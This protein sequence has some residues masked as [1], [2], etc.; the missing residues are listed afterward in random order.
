[1]YGGVSSV[2]FLDRMSNCNT[3]KYVLLKLAQSNCSPRKRKEI[4]VVLIIFT[5]MLIFSI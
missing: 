5:R 2:V 4:E 3:K 1:M